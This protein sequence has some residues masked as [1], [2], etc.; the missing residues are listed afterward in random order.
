MKFMPWLL[1]TGMVFL[2][3]ACE[4][5]NLPQ[6]EECPSEMT[7]AQKKENELHIQ[8]FS[9]GAFTIEKKGC[10]LVI[11]FQIVVPFISINK[12]RNE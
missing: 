9:G 1:T 11:P 3:A 6:L 4:S 7:E 10:G 2:A 8:E 5:Q 12:P